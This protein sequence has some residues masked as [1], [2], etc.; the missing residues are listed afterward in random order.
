MGE[1]SAEYADYSY[2]TP[3]RCRVDGQEV[4]YQVYQQE[5]SALTEGKEFQEAGYMTG[6]DVREAMMD[7]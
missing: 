7:E 5:L 1:F 3:T 2:E 4:T 6:T